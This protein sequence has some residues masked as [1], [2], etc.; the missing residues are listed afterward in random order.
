MHPGNFPKC[1]KDLILGHKLL[2][3]HKPP[4]P[5]IDIT[6]TKAPIKPTKV[7]HLILKVGIKNLKKNLM[8]DS[9]HIEL[10]RYSMIWY[11]NCILVGEIVAFE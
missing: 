10:P 7:K 5:R 2:P 9:A 4:R 6:K 8:Q 1:N 11:G 3:K